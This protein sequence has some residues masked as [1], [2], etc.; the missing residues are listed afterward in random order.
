MRGSPLADIAVTESPRIEADAK[1]TDFI[2]AQG[3][4]LY[5]WLERGG[6]RTRDDEAQ[7]GDRV[8]RL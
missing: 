7:G 4:A 8:H 3:G 1:A 2:R 5:V 6:P